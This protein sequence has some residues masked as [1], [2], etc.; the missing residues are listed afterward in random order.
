MRDDVL[1]QRYIKALVGARHRPQRSTHQSSDIIFFACGSSLRLKLR[2]F[3]VE[4]W[5]A[6]I[7][8]LEDTCRPEMLPALREGDRSC[9]QRVEHRPT[10]T[11]DD[12]VFKSL[13]Q[14]VTLL[15]E[16]H[17][18][19]TMFG[20]PQL[21]LQTLHLPLFLLCFTLCLLLQPISHPSLQETH[22]WYPRG[23]LFW[24]QTIRT[25]C[26]TPSHGWRLAGVGHSDLYRLHGLSSSR[27]ERPKLAA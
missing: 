25:W 21:P 9:H 14:L 7:W 6:F 8:P 18:T 22:N 5:S 27:S 20:F 4:V 12:R 13:W 1:I 24:L 10:P 19:E 2:L 15:L 3:I 16:F 23:Q 11:F 17:V 26:L